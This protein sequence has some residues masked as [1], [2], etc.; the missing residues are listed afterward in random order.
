[1][2]DLKYTD[3]EWPKIIKIFNLRGQRKHNR[4][5]LKKAKIHEIEKQRNRGTRKPRGK[6]L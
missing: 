3:Q 2:H 5:S 1:M 4:I 6:F